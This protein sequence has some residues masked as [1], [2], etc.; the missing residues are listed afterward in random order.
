MS[1]LRRPRPRPRAMVRIDPGNYYARLGVSPLASTEEIAALIRT[2]R[3]ALSAKLGTRAGGG[4]GQEEL[5]IT[6]YDEMNDHIGDARKRKA[7]DRAHPMNALLTVQEK[8]TDALTDQRTVSGLVTA[9][10]VSEVGAEGLLPSPDSLPLWRP[11]R[12]AWPDLE[13]ALI[14]FLV[15]DDEIGALD[16]DPEDD[17]DSLTAGAADE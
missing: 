5:E 3:A 4:F 17:R 2:R 9:W 16:E 7:Y 12:E 11:A 14:P 13:P 1:A 6:R 10:L 15:E 8:V